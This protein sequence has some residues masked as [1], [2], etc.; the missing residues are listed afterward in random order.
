MLTLLGDRP[1]GAWTEDDVAH[2]VAVQRRVLDV[3]R[4]RLDVADDRHRCGAGPARARSAGRLRVTEHGARVG[5]RRDGHRVRDHLVVRLRLRRDVPGTGLWLNN[6]LG[7]H[8]LNRGAPPAPGE[9]LR[10]QHG[11]DGRPPRR[12]C[13]AGHRQPR[14]RPDHD[15]PAAGAGVVRARRRQPAGGDRPA[16]AAR[17]PPGG[18]RRRRSRRLGAGGGRGGPAAAR[19]STCRCAA[20]TRSRCT[21]AGSG[22]RCGCQTAMSRPPPTPA[23]RVRHS[24]HPD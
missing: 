12:R 2:L 14:R 8:E 3:R 22:R 4:D 24:R 6:C 17:Q 1:A 7:E 21:S 5:G 23:A 15:G 19:A 18:R 20:T 11:A 16:P 10:Q 13:G 9:R